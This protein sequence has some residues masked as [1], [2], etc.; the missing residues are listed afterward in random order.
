MNDDR[1]FSLLWPKRTAEMC[2]DVCYLLHIVQYSPASCCV[3]R[4]R[5]TLV[6]SS[7][8]C[9][10][11]ELCLETLCTHSGSHSFGHG[12][13]V[14]G[15]QCGLISEDALGTFNTLSLWLTNY[16]AFSYVFTSFTCKLVFL[17][18]YFCLQK[19]LWRR[20][21]TIVNP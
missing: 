18:T 7:P 12:R 21:C 8:Y 4:C 17:Q 20:C 19:H 2:V 13:A 9:S 16:H 1:T 5:D 14:P 10:C 15:E 3:S 6:P 11:P